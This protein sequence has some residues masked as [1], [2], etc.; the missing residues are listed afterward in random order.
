MWVVARA[1]CHVVQVEQSQMAI[2]R[3][4]AVA[5][6]K[7]IP[8]MTWDATKALVLFLWEIIKNPLVLKDKLGEAQY[9]LKEVHMY[10]CARAHRDAVTNAGPPFRNVHA[11]SR[12]IPFRSLLCKEMTQCCRCGVL[13][14]EHRAPSVVF[15]NTSY[16]VNFEVACPES[17]PTSQPSSKPV[18]ACF[19]TASNPSHFVFVCRLRHL[20]SI[21]ISCLA[22][23]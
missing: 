2:T 23:C 3:K 20:C 15:V 4:K 18:T 5:M 1:A 9:H 6:V 7:R 19:K 21:I 14:T 8:V 22:G 10:A 12:T 13:H 16:F 17:L 11:Y